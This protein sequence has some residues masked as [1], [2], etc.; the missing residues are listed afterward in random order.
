MATSTAIWG[1][2]RRVT[3]RKPPVPGTTGAGGSKTTWISWIQWT[4]ALLQLVGWKD[5][6][7]GL[8]KIHRGLIDD[9]TLYMDAVY[10][11]E[12]Q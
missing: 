5:D 4:Q 1:A 10:P 8:Q 6:G 3:R 9:A 11:F 7:I 12:V 2:P